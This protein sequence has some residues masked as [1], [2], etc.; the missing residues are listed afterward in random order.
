MSETTA[1]AVRSS[2]LAPPAKDE[3][4]AMISMA[5]S[6]AKAQGFLPAHFFGQPYKILAAILYGRDLGI[7]A[8]NALQHIIVIEGK[9]TADAQLI[10]M[11]VRRAGHQMVDATSDTSSTVTITRNDGT[12]HEATFTIQDA[13]RAGLVRAGGAWQK[14]PAA[15]LYARALTACARKGAQD[16]LMGTVYTPEEL[17]AEVD[18]EGV[19]ISPPGVPTGEIPIVD[20]DPESIKV[21]EAAQDIPPATTKLPEAPRESPVVETAT[22]T[23]AP[24]DAKRRG[25]PIGSKNAAK[26]D[27]IAAK[28]NELGAEMVREIVLPPPAATFGEEIIAAADENHGIAEAETQVLEMRSQLHG[29]ASRLRKYQ[30]LE[31]GA[32]IPATEL[33]EKEIKRTLGI[34]IERKFGTGVVLEDIEEPGLQEAIEDLKGFLAKYETAEE[35]GTTQEVIASPPPQG[36]GPSSSDATVVPVHRA[37][38]RNVVAA[39]K[40]GGEA[41]RVDP[42]AS[43]DRAR[44]LSDLRNRTVALLATRE[45]LIQLTAKDEDRLRVQADGVME[46][47]AQNNFQKAIKDLDAGQLSLLVERAKAAAKP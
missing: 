1:L 23:V 46:N 40:R 19:V 5:N 9:A 36:T 6:L 8:T 15:M 10:G 11:L 22:G 14:Y 38:T 7:S 44:H 2:Y 24:Q 32:A 43:L 13:Q 17:G 16:A 30:Y 39:A 31:K 18:S 35:E 12:V 29:L 3:F 26:E 47:V 28:I 27:P 37:I 33:W 20:A 45:G 34:F 4:E 41:T 21:L 25:R 42:Q